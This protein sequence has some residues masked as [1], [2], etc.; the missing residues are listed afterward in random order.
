[1]KPKKIIVGLLFGGR[2][3]EH[4][5]SL[6]SA[7]SIYKYLDRS[8]YEVLSIY[9]TR[10]GE[11]KKV[12]SPLISPDELEEG[13]SFSFLPWKKIAGEILDAD[14]YFPVLHGPYGEDGTIQGLLEL[15]D[16]PFVGAS[17]LGSALGMDK[18]AM[19]AAFTARNIPLAGYRLFLETEWQKDRPA[20]GRL[21]LQEFAFPF[22]VKP[23]NLGSSVGITKVKEAGRISSALETAFS[24]DR[25]VLVEEGIR[26]RELECGVLGNNEPRSSL[27]G[28]VMP[29]REFYDYR[30]KYLEGK[31][32]FK[33]PA[34][35]PVEK[36][37]EVQYLAVEAFKAV[38]G[39]GMARVDF[40]LEDHTGRLLVNEVNTIPGFTEISM[41]PKLWEASGLSYPNLLDELISLGFERHASK[42]KRLDRNSP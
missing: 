2:S 5:V 3:A 13:A 22:F 18:A 12:P 25:K 29:F 26:G 32:K 20:V 8:R 28:E 6:I 33:I 38:D 27:P 24:Y 35:L 39:A 40:F 41:Y 37:R 7:S 17:V 1:M 14:I 23:A 31:T 15:A 9:I 11:W 4:E 21:L 42:K 36:V 10:N 16:V 30:D 34:E 19:K